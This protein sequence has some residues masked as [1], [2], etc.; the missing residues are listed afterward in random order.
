MHAVT[1]GIRYSDKH[2][3]FHLETLDAPVITLGTKSPLPF[4]KQQPDLLGGIHCSLFNNAWGTNYI[5]WFG[6]DMSFR[7]ILRA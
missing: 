1:G 4:S 2:G 3:D 5:M 6:E 7:F